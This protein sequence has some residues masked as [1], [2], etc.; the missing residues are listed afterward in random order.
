MKLT[1]DSKT[2]IAAYIGS[3]LPEY[4][5]YICIVIYEEGT[6]DAIGNI[7]HDRI[8]ELFEILSRA[9]PQDPTY[10]NRNN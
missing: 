3:K 10:I 8:R 1:D 9:D 7:A 4:A 6:A 2:E 5:Q